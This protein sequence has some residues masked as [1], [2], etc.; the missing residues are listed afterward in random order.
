MFFSINPEPEIPATSPDPCQ[1]S[2]SPLHHR[3][4]GTNCRVFQRQTGPFVSSLCFLCL[5]SSSFVKSAISLKSM[6]IS[7]RRGGAGRPAERPA[8]GWLARRLLA[9]GS[10]VLLLRH[11]KFYFA[12]PF[13]IL[14][15]Y[16]LLAA[17]FAALHTHSPRHLLKKL[18]FMAFGSILPGLGP[19]YNWLKC[20]AARRFLP[21]RPFR[22]R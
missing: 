21:P 14:Y 20:C 8:A 9:V 19:G 1:L 4:L 10:A 22:M 3:F 12:F 7:F 6:A 17:A 13:P 11:N 16:A 18:R 15:T 2:A 5:P